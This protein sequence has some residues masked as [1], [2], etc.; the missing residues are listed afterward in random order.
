MKRW[1]PIQEKGQILIQTAVLLVV[2]L[3]FAALAVDV[4]KA[5]AER[6]RMQNAADAAALA[7]ARA[8]CMNQGADAA[9]AAGVRFLLENGVPEANTGGD[10]VTVDGNWVRAN[11]LIESEALLSGVL[12][13]N[14]TNVTAQAAAACGAA[15][16][17][18][19][20]WP[21]AFELDLWAEEACK[22]QKIAIWSDDTKEA[23]CVLLNEE[24]GV[25]EERDS[26][27]DCYICEW[28]GEPISVF[29]STSRGWID[30]TGS[31]ADI[32][33]DSCTASGC[34]ADELK[35]HIGSPSG[36]LVELG[37]NGICMAGNRGVR[38]SVQQPVNARGGDTISV[39]IYSDTNCPVANN[40]SGTDAE[41]YLVT[42]FGCI[43]VIG[44]EQNF[45]LAHISG[46]NN[47]RLKGKAILAEVNCSGGC[48][49]ACGNTDGSA[50]EP[51][52]A[53][54]VSLLE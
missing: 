34:G 24:T 6:R 7:G 29:T 41:S 47:K 9:H 46:D 49:T 10:A 32:Y 1:W 28:A 18:C 2:L 5:Y 16:S 20:L 23:A 45:E 50:A 33:N 39:P 48:F 26:I 19:G 36:S 25:L 40:C 21:I 43:N 53:R 44:W 31:Q 27:C 3:G 38:A 12:G 17:A 54:A 4:G 8:L 22:P 42:K 15:R 30:L 14:S 11:A 52:E 13:I 37:E 35:C 51:W